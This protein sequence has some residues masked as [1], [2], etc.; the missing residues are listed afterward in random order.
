VPSPRRAPLTP[1][2]THPLNSRT[3]QQDAAASA[4]FLHSWL[5]RRFM[6]GSAILF[7]VVVT[8]YATTWFLRAFD[9]LFSPLLHHFFGL[10]LFGLG[11]I[12]S[13]VFITGT[14]AFASSWAGSGMLALGEVVIRRLPLVRH[15]YSASKQVSAALNPSGEGAGSQAFR[16][17]VLIRH[18]RH[19]EFAVAFTT[20][21]STLRGL[22]GAETKLV[23]VYVPTNHLYIGDVFLLDKADVI[24]TSMSVREGL[25]VVLSAGAALPPLLAQRDG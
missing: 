21:Q 23:C 8:F 11:F 18:P 25:E 6:S 9:G 22:D 2:A 13:M 1:P 5:S 7:P 12:T 14:G 17:C 16:S 19:G 20:G 15:I 10:N 4:S 24:A 3:P